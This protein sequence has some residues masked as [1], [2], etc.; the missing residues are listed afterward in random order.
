MHVH[1]VI[2]NNRLIAFRAIFSRCV[3]EEP[4]AE[5]LPH[6][7][8]VLHARGNWQVISIHDA[9]QLLSHVLRTSNRSRVNEI[10][11]AP[12]IREIIRLPRFIN[13]EQR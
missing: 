2:I 8:I 9:N 10:L 12:N 1:R 4:C 6:L 5:C 3:V 13:C 11:M 7:G